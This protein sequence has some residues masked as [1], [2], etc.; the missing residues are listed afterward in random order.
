MGENTVKSIDITRVLLKMVILRGRA[1]SVPVL[2]WILEILFAIVSLSTV[3][4]A[5]RHYFPIRRALDNDTY[6]PAGAWIVCFITA[7]APRIRSLAFITSGREQSIDLDRQFL[8]FD[9]LAEV[10]VGPGV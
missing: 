3:A 9:R 6:E 5:T 7:I 8:Q 1:G 2:G 4:I 10:S